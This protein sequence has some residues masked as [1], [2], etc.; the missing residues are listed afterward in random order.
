MMVS[1]ISLYIQWA[2]S[3][4]ISLSPRRTIK[5]SWPLGRVSC[6]VPVPAREIFTAFVS[7][8]IHLKLCIIF[9][10]TVPN[11]VVGRRILR[12]RR[13]S[14]NL[15]T[16]VVMEK[17]ALSVTWRRRKRKCRLST[18]ARSSRITATC[19]LESFVT[20]NVFTSG[21]WSLYLT[22]STSYWRTCQCHGSRCVRNR[23]VAF[24]WNCVIV[25]QWARRMNLITNPKEYLGRSPQ[26]HH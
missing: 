10:L 9:W 1:H 24:S 4:D 14:G 23:A 13:E 21:H 11:L 19:P 20:I 15:S 7:S 16:L 26:L 18:C 3:I 17:S 5:L 12:R 8:D 2:F 6:Q 25:L 22:L